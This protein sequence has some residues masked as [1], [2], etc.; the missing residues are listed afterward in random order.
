LPYYTMYILRLTLTL[1]VMF[2]VSI[3]FYNLTQKIS[4]YEEK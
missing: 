1:L 4:L 2:F 3:F